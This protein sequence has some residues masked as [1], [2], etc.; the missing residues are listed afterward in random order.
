MDSHIRSTIVHCMEVGDFVRVGSSGA[1]R[2]RVH[3]VDDG[4]LIGPTLDAP[5]GDPVRTCLI[6]LAPWAEQGR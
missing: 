5:N 6:G 2:F 4:V 1:R 3:E